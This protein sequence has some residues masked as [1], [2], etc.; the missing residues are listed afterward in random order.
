MSFFV[1]KIPLN[2][3]ERYGP[4]RSPEKNLRKALLYYNTDFENKFTF[5]C[6]R[7]K[8]SLICKNLRPLLPRMFCAKFGNWHNGSSEEVFKKIRQHIFCYFVIISLKRAGSFIYNT[9]SLHQG[10]LCVK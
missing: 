2:K 8:W 10:M 6:L 7:I 4:Y 1:Q 5:S 9:N 3:L